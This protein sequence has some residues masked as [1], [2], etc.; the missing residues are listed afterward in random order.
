MVVMVSH[1]L[2]LKWMVVKDT[3]LIIEWYDLGQTIFI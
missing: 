1:L 2:N 3:H